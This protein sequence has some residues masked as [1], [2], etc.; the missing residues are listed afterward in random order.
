MAAKRVTVAY[1]LEDTAHEQFIP[2][3]VHRVAR[4][5][6]DRVSVRDHIIQAWGGSHSLA[7]FRRA[8]RDMRDAMAAQHASSIACDI[9]V[10]C[11]DGN[12]V[13]PA[14]KRR[15]IEDLVGKYVTKPIVYAIPDPYIEW[16]YL[17]DQHA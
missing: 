2:P 12:G 7:H 14:Q 13:G 11:V 9:I 6:P 5:L 10:V 16:W 3:L 4:E 15:E 1:F 8:M 17:C